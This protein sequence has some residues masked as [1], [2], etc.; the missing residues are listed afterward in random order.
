MKNNDELFSEVQVQILTGIIATKIKTTYSKNEHLVILG[1][2]NACFMFLSDLCKQLTEFKNLEIDFVRVMSYTGTEAG[3]IMLWIPPS[4]SLKNKNV[5]IVDTIN[6]TGAT[7]QYVKD[8]IKDEGA[9]NIKTCTLIDRVK[10]NDELISDIAGAKIAKGD[11][12]Y[13]YGLDYKQLYR[14]ISS[15][16]KA[17]QFK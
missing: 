3:K 16:N 7:L 17:V 8:K 13:G 1:V 14:Q 2:L 10:N 5:L 9:F 4:L 15:I 6:E 12:L 11:F